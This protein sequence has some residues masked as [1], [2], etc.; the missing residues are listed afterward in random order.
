MQVLHLKIKKVQ[1][2]TPILGILMA[3]FVPF[4]YHIHLLKICHS[5]YHVK[6]DF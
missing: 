5:F 1:K 6:T 2:S 3:F 4:Y